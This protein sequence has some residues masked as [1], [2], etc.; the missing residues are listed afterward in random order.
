M[1]SDFRDDLLQSYSEA[2]LVHHIRASPRLAP[3]SVFLLSATLLAK[4]YELFLIE[5]MV[6]ATEI[7][8]QLGI[9][10][11]SIKRIIIYERSAYCI[12]ERIQGST[13]E[14]IWPKLSWFT[15]VKVA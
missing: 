7:A 5:D 12:M 14:N 9:R 2:E 8:R 15:T 3:S 13:L 1:N 4:C 11:P 6:K 10:T